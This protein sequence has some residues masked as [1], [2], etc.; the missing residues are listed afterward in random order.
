MLGDEDNGGGGD[1]G[2]GTSGEEQWI[3]VPGE[4]GADFYFNTVNKKLWS[5]TGLPKNVVEAP[6]LDSPIIPRR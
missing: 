5:G 2:D 4:N 1:D 6:S 3:R